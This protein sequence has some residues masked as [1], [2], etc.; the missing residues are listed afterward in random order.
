MIFLPLL[1]LD[2]GAK[3]PE[4]KGFALFASLFIH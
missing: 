3:I 1:L 2:R 4:G